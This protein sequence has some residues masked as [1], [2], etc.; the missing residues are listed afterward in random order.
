M[1]EYTAACLSGVLSLQDALSVVSLRGRLF[2]KLAEGAMLSVM[3][4][5][6]ELRSRLP[7]ALSIAAVNAP[8]LCV[9]SGPVSEIE[10]LQN[11]LESEDV[12]CRRIHISVAAHSTMVESIMDEFEERL[13]K[14][15][16]SS[17]SIPLISNVTGDWLSAQEASSPQYWVRHLRQTV[18][19]SDG[20]GTLLRDSKTALLEVGPGRTLSS[21]GRMHPLA[22]DSGPI[23]NSMRHPRESAHDLEFILGILGQLWSAGAEIEWDRFYDDR[24]LPRIPLPTYPFDHQSYWIEPGVATA[25]AR[26]AEQRLSP[27]EWLYL[28]SWKSAMPPARRE[29]PYDGAWLVLCDDDSL[30]SNIQT[31]INSR[32][33]ALDGGP[34]RVVRVVSGSTFDPSAD[35]KVVV[36]PNEA[37]DFEKL[38]D[39]VLSDDIERL[40]IVDMWGVE[41]LDEESRRE[42]WRP[43]FALAKALGNLN[44]VSIDWLTVVCNVFA[45]PGEE[46]RSIDPLKSLALGPIAVSPRE[47]PFVRTR[48]ADISR[49][50]LSDPRRIS[51]RLILEFDAT[52]DRTAI[53]RAKSRFTQEYVATEFP[54]TET[55]RTWLKEGGV[56]LVTG[57]LGGLGLEVAGFLAREAGA[58]VV[59]VG[60]AGLPPREEWDDTGGTHV[61]ADRIRAVRKIEQ[62]GGRVFS[63]SVDITDRDAV[64]HLVSRIGTEVGPI[65]GVFHLAGTLDDNLIALKTEADFASVL[66]PKVEGTIN[67]WDELQS[68]EPELFVLFSSVSSIL[69]LPG[70]ADY[71][72]ANAFLNAFALRHADHPVTDVVAIDWCAWRE[73]GMAARISSGTHTNGVRASGQPLTGTVIADSFGA[74]TAEVTY[75]SGADWFLSE[76]RTLSGAAFLPGTAYFEIAHSMFRE[77]EQF[78][79]FQV[80]DLYFMAPVGGSDRPTVRVTCHGESFAVES[81]A[82]TESGWVR[83]AEGQLLALDDR[84]ELD[85][86]LEEAKLRCD[87]VID[88][89]EDPQSGTRQSDFVLFGPRW[90]N[91]NRILMGRGELVAEIELPSDFRSDLEQYHVHPAVFDTATG[92]GLRL[93]DGYSNS[94]SFYVPVSYGSVSVYRPLPSRIFSHVRL[95]E[96]SSAEFVHLDA[97]LLDSEG[98]VL[99]RIVDFGMKHVSPDVLQGAT[100]GA[101]TG[102]VPRGMHSEARTAFGFDVAKGLTNEEGLRLMDDVLCLHLPQQVVVSTIDL[103]AWIEQLDTV[104]EELSS[105]ADGS[106]PL[107]ADQARPELSTTYLAPRDELEAQI[108]EILGSVL[109]VSAVG[110]NDNFYEL[111]GHSLLLTQSVARIRKAIGRSVSLEAAFANP[112][113]ASI[114]AN[115][116]ADASDG[117]QDEIPELKTVNRSKFEVE[118]SDQDK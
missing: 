51:E 58:R 56:Y 117:A 99:A 14:I 80:R 5:E 67:L 3:L 112:T 114:A 25:S 20:L 76:H 78:R 72:A 7:A 70:Q 55:E 47:M 15:R 16:F 116:G 73:A 107:A 115:I 89:G 84:G 57:G 97:D 104:H 105:S 62:E 88:Y 118:V 30:M 29:D 43:V 49:E 48:V 109:G 60:R 111:G 12:E 94:D 102:M 32:T 8:E 40:R 35:G 11:S 92:V 71:T 38:F 26:S 83:C 37:G 81:R 96:E 69:G 50:L 36:R 101:D 2:E 74:R 21:L 31:V 82:A 18:R 52:K 33:A 79:P 64:K 53:L 34:T 6:D 1:G 86:D 68:S 95:R 100:G 63:Y 10:K 46:G 66:A 91:V 75:D 19:F 85:E 4:S 24:A 106:S 39:L 27:D 110:V 45:L 59:L 98:R 108:A 13:S 23:V 44:G 54:R 113:V 65:D 22:R 9:A 42:C 103:A 77:Q 87:E 93:V 28:P 17:P 61:A 90:Q 41:R